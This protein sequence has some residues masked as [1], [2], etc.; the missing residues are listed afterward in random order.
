M[1]N[2]KM[3]KRNKLNCNSCNNEKKVDQTK[4]IIPMNE[5]I[6]SRKTTTNVVILN[7]NL[8]KNNNLRDK[9]IIE[10]FNTNSNNK[11]GNC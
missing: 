4:N 6:N 1:N 9:V 8:F 5:I 11:C 7:Y 2:F 10:T 3:F